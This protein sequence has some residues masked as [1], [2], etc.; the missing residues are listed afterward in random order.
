MS[1]KT[2]KSKRNRGGGAPKSPADAPAPDAPAPDAPAPA[3]AS[4]RARR[5]DGD[6][7]LDEVN[8]EL[9]RDRLYGLLRKAAP[10]AIG[11]VLLLVGSIGVSEYL[12]G[13]RE[14]E[15]RAAGE[16]ISAA[17]LESDPASAYLEIAEGADEGV[18]VLAR[19]RAAASLAEAGQTD[20]AADAYAA[21]ASDLSTPTRYRHLAAIRE[22]LVRGETMAPA[23]AI[24]RLE[25]LTTVDAPY[26]AV[27]LELA[28]VAELRAGDVDAARARLMEAVSAQNATEGVVLRASALLEALGGPLDDAA[29]PV[30]Q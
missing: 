9:R 29:A 19:L 28:A 22:V 24:A 20:A 8:E 14:A 3:T 26:R 6:I 1:K 18:A 5:D 23:D 30:D 7:F 13:A 27:A 10:F 25:P 15:A 12:A 16:A 17:A 11:A 2:S 21:L 4:Q